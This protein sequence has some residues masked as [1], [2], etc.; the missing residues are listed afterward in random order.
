M[1]RNIFKSNNITNC[2]RMALDNSLI[3]HEHLNSINISN[4]SLVLLHRNDFPLIP[5][6]QRHRKVLRR[7]SDERYCNLL[8]YFYFIAQLL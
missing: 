7:K 3:A 8:K 1:N 2:Q 6:I 4:I 5:I